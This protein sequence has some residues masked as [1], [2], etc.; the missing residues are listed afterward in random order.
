MTNNEAQ[1]I[2]ILLDKARQ[3]A[4]LAS[5]AELARHMRVR[6]PTLSQW[7]SGTVPL[8]DARIVQ[9]AEI[10]S[11]P[12]EMWLVVLQAGKAKNATVRRA[13]LD[14]YT[15]LA[16]HLGIAAAVALCVIGMGENTLVF[17]TFAASPFLPMHIMSI[18]WHAW[19]PSIQCRRPLI[20]G[21]ARLIVS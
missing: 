6:P 15:H 18:Q 1:A 17:S 16:K 12:P 20:D 9:L 4:G 19:D 3:R 21:A 11:D 14:A 5:D 13:W 2:T 8:P 7:R 10:C